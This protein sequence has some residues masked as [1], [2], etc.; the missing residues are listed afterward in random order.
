MKH[1]KPP[2]PFLPILKM[3]DPN[4]HYPVVF[5]G[6]TIDQGASRDW[7]DEIASQLSHYNGFILNP[8]RDNWDATWEQDPTPGTNFYGQVTW[9]FEAQDIADVL[10]YNFLPNSQSPV[11][12]L[13]L[14]HWSKPDKTF[15][16]CPKTFWRYGN[17]K[18]FCDRINVNFFETETEMMQALHK[19]LTAD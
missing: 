17:V 18:M 3:V 9:E 14:G 6:G 12:M 16:V 8:R 4:E 11:T 15:V 5:L 13:E 7:Q 1:I 10:V 19:H 2:T